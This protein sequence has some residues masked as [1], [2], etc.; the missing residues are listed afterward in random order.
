MSFPRKWCRKPRDIASMGL[1]QLEIGGQGPQCGENLT[2]PDLAP[3]KKQSRA[4]VINNIPYISIIKQKGQMGWTNITEITPKNHREPKTLGH[5]IT[6]HRLCGARLVRKEHL[7]LRLYECKHIFK[8]RIVH[9]SSKITWNPK[10]GLLKGQTLFGKS[11]RILVHLC[12]PGRKPFLL[13]PLSFVRFSDA[14]TPLASAQIRCFLSPGVSS[15]EEQQWFQAA[16]GSGEL[17]GP[18]PLSWDP[19]AKIFTRFPYG[20][21][22]S[23]WWFNNT[24][25]YLG[26]FQHSY[27]RLSWPKI[28]CPSSKKAGQIKTQHTNNQTINESNKSIYHYQLSI[29]FSVCLSIYVIVYVQNPSK[30]TLSLSTRQPG[31]TSPWDFPPFFHGDPPHPQVGPQIAKKAEEME[32]WKYKANI[33]KYHV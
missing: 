29:Y 30:W 22:P 12:F 26:L 10:M 13:L 2:M 9:P 1:H 4:N 20:L 17:S 28:L 24:Y 23:P 31:W 8:A 6:C 3:P 7:S 5:N 33:G 19:L 18:R 21:H 15:V 14:P 25:L 11:Q 27:T 16:S 32:T